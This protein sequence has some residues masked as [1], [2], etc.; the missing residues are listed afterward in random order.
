MSE[1]LIELGETKTDRLLGSVGH[2][3]NGTSVS[4]RA[5]GAPAE[6]GSSRRSSCRCKSACSISGNIWAIQLQPLRD[7][8]GNVRCAS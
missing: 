7:P 1:P 8:A 5:T 2:I 6:I 4:V 3:K